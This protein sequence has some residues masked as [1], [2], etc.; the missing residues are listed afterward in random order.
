MKLLPEDRLVWSPTVVNS[1][2]NRER[3]SSGVNS[4][5]QEFKFQ[6]EEYLL[7]KVNESGQAS[8]LDI[9]CG[10][11]NALIQ[12]AEYFKKLGQQD[13]VKLKGIDLV[14]S[15]PTMDSGITC[16]ELIA[17]S[18]INWNPDQTYD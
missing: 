3:N 1:R 15:F 2:M 8:W 12:T 13:K 16:L 18:I 10:H 17:E 6:P 7:T 11:G 9:C 4:Y 5:E 14:D